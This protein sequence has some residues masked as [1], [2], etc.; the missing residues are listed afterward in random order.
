MKGIVL[1]MGR[2]GTMWVAAAL[3]ESG[4]LDARHESSESWVDWGSWGEVEVNSFLWNDVDEIRRVFPGMPIIHLVRDGR[5]VV[6]SVMNRPRPGRTLE[7]ACKMWCIRN[8]T[9]RKA[10]HKRDRFRLEDLTKDFTV[11]SRLANRLGSPYVR[12]WAWD[13]LVGEKVNQNKQTEWPRF[14]DWSAKNRDIFWQIC[15]E[16][17]RQYG[18]HAP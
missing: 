4:S 2:S 13:R 3:A 14:K 12:R 8:A 16:E 17:M 6:R 15:R 11:F 5:D 1:A 7:Q 9:I 10:I 18:Y